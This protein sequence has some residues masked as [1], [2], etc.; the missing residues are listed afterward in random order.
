[1]DVLTLIGVTGFVTQFFKKALSRFKLVIEG[2]AAV[3][4]SVVV[5]V[6]VVLVEA[7]KLDMPLSLA[8][9]PVLVQVIVGAN[10]GYSLLKV[11]GG[12]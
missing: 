5:S 4:L 12:K 7:I 3:V 6:G 2:T 1:M 11:A 8:L 10:M 9:I